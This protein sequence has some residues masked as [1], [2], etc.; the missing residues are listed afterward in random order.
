[1]RE[2]EKS[3]RR[4]PEPSFDRQWTRFF[5]GDFESQ[6]LYGKTVE[7]DLALF[8]SAFDIRP[9]DLKGRLVLDAGCGS[10]RLDASL[11]ALGAQVIALDLVDSIHRAAWRHAP[12]SIRFVQANLLYAPFRQRSFDYVWSAGVLHHTGA[13]E[14]GCRTL[15][16]LVK[17]GGQLAVW[18]YSRD[19]FSPF[20]TAR[21]A[22]PF[23]HRFP[24]PVRYAICW[25]LAIPLVLAGPLAPGI[26]RRA[27]PVN[28]RSFA[29]IKF[30]LYDALTPRYVE[31]YRFQEVYDWFVQS[32]LSKV[33][34]WSELGVTGVREN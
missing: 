33:R 11:A 27:R 3:A 30:G 19:R 24:D 14:Y 32:G 23:V 6:T 8:L 10:A 4:W 13:T 20:L 22:L 18:L 31:R 17:V 15:A 9:A 1:M 26:G 12:A 16:D 2:A 25:V 7:E 28:R 21:W 29:T 34:R 5:Q